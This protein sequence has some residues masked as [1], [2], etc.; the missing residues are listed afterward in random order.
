MVKSACLGMPHIGLNGEICDAITDLIRTNFK[1]KNNLD[2]LCA[3]VRRANWQTQ[4]D[5]GIDNIPSNDFSIYDNVLDTTMLVGNIPKRYY[6]EGGLVPPEI[7]FSM[8]RGQQKDKF[9]VHGM[10]TNSWFNTSF[11]YIVPEI[12]QPM[13]FAYSDNKPISHF[14]EAKKIFGITTNVH[15]LGPVSYIMLSDKDPNNSGVEISKTNAMQKLLPVYA[16][17]FQNLNRLNAK[18][19]VFEEPCLAKDLNREWQATYK[20]FYSYLCGSMKGK[21][22]IHLVTS[23]GSLG[24]NLECTM[25]LGVKS[26]HYDFVNGQD[27]INELLNS[28]PENTSLSL[29][30]VDSN[31]GWITDLNKAITIAEKVCEKI[32]KDRVIIAPSSSMNLC[33]LD[34][35]TNQNY[36]PFLS[37][38]KDKLKEVVIIAKAL[39]EGRSAVKDKLLKNEKLIKSLQK[40]SNGINLKLNKSLSSKQKQTYKRAPFKERK[41]AQALT[42]KKGVL[43]LPITD[44]GSLPTDQS[45]QTTS[46]LEDVLK[47]SITD[48]LKLQERFLDVVN[49]G[50]IERRNNIEYF[51]KLIDGIDLTP[52][53]ASRVSG[54][55][56][57]YKPIIHN[58]S[59]KIEQHHINI[60]KYCLSVATKPM[61]FS[62]IGPI[63]LVNASFVPQGVNIDKC[64]EHF[65]HLLG[66]QISKLQKIG[67]K[68]IMIDEPYLLNKMP[69]R[70]E[71]TH[72]YIRKLAEIFKILAN[73]AN[74]DVQI[75]LHLKG[76]HCAEYIESI[77]CFDA[78]VLFLAATNTRLEVLDAFVSYKYPND[79]AIGLF[80]GNSARVPTKP[81]IHSNLRKCLRV[82]EESQ[83]WITTDV[84]TK[85]RTRKDTTT[86]FST[87]ANITNEA[88]KTLL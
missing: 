18:N 13:S 61:R 51:A 60:A 7:Y 87:I 50:E 1:T 28:L 66:Q 64:Y 15:L 38:A 4:I 23:F 68:H 72:K 25:S 5:I 33:P 49:A 71:N 16:E 53:K 77:S 74:N 41:K 56:Y 65:A 69:L 81:E 80:N 32:G 86:I 39:N 10:Q 42:T 85:N 83:L 40:L 48:N 27:S 21:L 12:S 67:I 6:W 88:R 35:S 26:L 9:D 70:S 78:D 63:S 47:A 62:L 24:N 36:A 54:D 2:V 73:Y 79:I 11:S 19:V 46:K 44:I 84:G 57:I 37:F 17:L 20:E 45:L 43:L 75:G 55:T 59:D 14:L 8:I 82:L 34:K 31:D 30:L 52:G 58:I 29:G 76:F 3:N 22:N